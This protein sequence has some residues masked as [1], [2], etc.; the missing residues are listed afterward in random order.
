[1][2]SAPQLARLERA[3]RASLPRFVL[4]HTGI[5]A[6]RVVWDGHALQAAPEPSPRNTAEVARALYLLRS[7]GARVD[8]D[9]DALLDRLVTDHLEALD[10]YDAAHA[11]W[12]AAVGNSPHG[13]TFWEA[14]QRRLPP[15]A[16]ETIQLGWTLSALCAYAPGAR[17]QQ[18]V[19]A[20]AA[21]ICGRLLRNQFPSTGLFRADAGSRRWWRRRQRTTDLSSQAYAIHG[22]ASY[23]IAFGRRGPIDRATACADTLHRLQGN[24]GQWWWMYDWRRGAVASPYPVYAVNQDAAVPLALD[25]IERAIGNRRYGEAVERGLAWL[26]GDNEAQTTLVDPDLGVVW[27]AVQQ[28]ASGFVVI[29][30]M[31]SYHA[32]RCLYWLYVDSQIRTGDW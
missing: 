5:L 11:L 18:A 31:Y 15:D 30:E 29:R 4:P 17:A 1:M 10:Y 8:I 24:R 25:T 13:A 16:S 14:L 22:L 26:F 2:V 32:A 6:R 27:R 28:A 12:A 20:L 21:D 7:R 9:P 3:C 19:V 23:G